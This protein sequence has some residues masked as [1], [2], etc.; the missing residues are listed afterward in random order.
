MTIE[1][2]AVVKDIIHRTS[3]VISFRVQPKQWVNFEAGQWLFVR[4]Y[5]GKNECVKPLSISSSPTDVG[6]IEF[7]KKITTSDYS[8]AL[9]RLKTGDPV[10]LKYPLGNFIFK[11]DCPKIAFLSGGIGITPIKGM[12]R[13]IKDR[14]WQTNVSLIY[15]NNTPRDIAFKEDLDKLSQHGNQFQVVYVIRNGADNW[16]GRTGLITDALVREAIPDYLERR[17]YVCGPPQMVH[18]M[19]KILLEALL[20]PKTQLITENFAGYA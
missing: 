8:R 5:D 20:I 19:K 3:D 12:C 7:T 4:V 15:G 16:P 2:S 18:A 17:F 13:C 10:N 6:Y 9:R 14:G 1:T 11:N